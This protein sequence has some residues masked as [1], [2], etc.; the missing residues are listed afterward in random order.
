[1]LVGL[2]LFIRPMSAGSDLHHIHSMPLQV[3]KLQFLYHYR[4]LEFL[5]AAMKEQS[6]VALESYQKTTLESM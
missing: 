3:F 6:L 2:N 1:M 4:I 5:P